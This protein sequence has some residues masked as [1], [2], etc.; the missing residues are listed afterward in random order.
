MRAAAGKPPKI[1]EIGLK[2]LD[3]LFQGR[4][5]CLKNFVT[6]I[7]QNYTPSGNPRFASQ[8]AAKGRQ[9]AQSPGRQR[10]LG[11]LGIFAQCSF[12]M[13]ELFHESTIQ[14]TV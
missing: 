7:S 11:S 8:P 10:V 2:I 12:D 13:E 9:T 3:K 1:S 14:Q 5:T 4:Y 6:P